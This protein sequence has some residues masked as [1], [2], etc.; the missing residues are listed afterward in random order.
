MDLW[1]SMPHSHHFTPPD[2]AYETD[3]RGIRPITRQLFWYLNTFSHET[4]I[5]TQSD[6]TPQVLNHGSVTQW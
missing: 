5:I 1:V 6:L 3:D 4:S 2:I